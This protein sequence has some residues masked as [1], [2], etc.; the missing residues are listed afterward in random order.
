[1]GNPESKITII[2]HCK[3]SS[4]PWTCVQEFG[5]WT[6]PSA[7]I[8]TSTEI[9][10][11]HRRVAITVSLEHVLPISMQD[12]NTGTCTCLAHP[13]IQ[14]QSRHQAVTAPILPEK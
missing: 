8:F 2:L 13:F 9:A 3:R 4:Y 6:E 5:L 1:M 10:K 7:N 12:L 14:C 11:F